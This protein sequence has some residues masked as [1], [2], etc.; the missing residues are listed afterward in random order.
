MLVELRLKNKIEKLV[1][2]FDE[3][4]LQDK[5][6]YSSPTSYFRGLKQGWYINILGNKQEKEI[7]CFLP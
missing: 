3:T 7:T 2:L 4:R 1:Y 5:N 6:P